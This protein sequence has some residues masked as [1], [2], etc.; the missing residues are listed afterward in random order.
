MFEGIDLHDS[1]TLRRPQVLRDALSLG[2]SASVI[3]E[4]NIGYDLPLRYTKSLI[5]ISKVISV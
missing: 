1:E 4:W 3:H 2:A 5:A